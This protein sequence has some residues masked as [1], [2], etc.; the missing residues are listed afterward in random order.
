MLPFCVKYKSIPFHADLPYMAKGK[1]S[2]RTLNCAL[3]HVNPVYQSI[4]DPK[5]KL[6]TSHCSIS[7]Y[8][9]PFDLSL[10]MWFNAELASNWFTAFFPT[11]KLLTPPPPYTTTNIISLLAYKKQ[12]LN[13]MT[14]IWPR[15]QNVILKKFFWTWKKFLSSWRFPM[16][17]PPPQRP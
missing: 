9:I 7:T 16:P 12:Q 6:R 4:H 8:S 1:T 10:S 13:N 15:P 17:R 11:Q 5:N 3:A 2:F 14:T